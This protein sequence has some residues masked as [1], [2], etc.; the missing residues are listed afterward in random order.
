MEKGIS[1]KITIRPETRKRSMIPSFVERYIRLTEMLKI[2]EL[3]IKMISIVLP[4]FS[5][6]DLFTTS[7]N[8]F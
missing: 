4:K 6:F 5:G 3:V 8:I 1:R 2:I 7:P